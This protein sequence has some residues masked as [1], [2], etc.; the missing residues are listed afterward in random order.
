[1]KIAAA[2]RATGQRLRATAPLRAMS[3]GSWRVADS[4]QTRLGSWSSRRKGPTPGSSAVCPGR[5]RTTVS[6]PCFHLQE[7]LVPEHS[8]LVGWA[9]PVPGLGIAGPGTSGGRLQRCAR[10]RRRRRDEGMSA[11]GSSRA[12]PGI[13]APHRRRRRS[14]LRLDD[15]ANRFENGIVLCHPHHY[16]GTRMATWGYRGASE[17]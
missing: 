10:N 2:A 12:S 5:C 14:L 9:R 1:M 7:G 16:P 8:I 3:K 13:L 15:T 6:H 11:P 17:K 4:P